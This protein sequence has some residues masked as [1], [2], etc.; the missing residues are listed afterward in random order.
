MNAQLYASTSNYVGISDLGRGESGSGWGKQAQI[1]LKQDRVGV[2]SYTYFFQDYTILTLD[3]V[4]LPK[5]VQVH[6]LKV[7]VDSCLL[8]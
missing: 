2:N 1:Q 3:M 6:N 4:V 5:I 8:G 7:L